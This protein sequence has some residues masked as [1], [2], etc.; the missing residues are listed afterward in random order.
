MK[1]MRF[2]LLT[3]AAVVVLG[4]GTESSSS[5]DS[6]IE[7]AT[8]AASLGIDLAQ[9]TKTPSGLYFR[10]LTEGA[11]VTVGVGSTI[12]IHYTGWLAN[13]TQFDANNPP[14]EPFQFAI[15]AGQVIPGFDEG[16]RGFKVGGRRQLIIP[17]S[18][19][20]GGV[21]VGPIPPNSILVFRIDLVAAQ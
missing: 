15:G 16:V 12:S 11:G 9:M 1:P 17:P 2:R 6:N 14:S 18:L 20:Y 3:A 8:F 19:G 7:T 10:D 21:P 13:G 5:E 4:C